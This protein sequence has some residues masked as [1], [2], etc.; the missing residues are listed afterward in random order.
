MNS[1]GTVKVYKVEKSYRVKEKGTNSYTSKR[2]KDERKWKYKLV[3]TD[4]YLRHRRLSCNAKRMA[5]KIY[6][7]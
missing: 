7:C 6:V 5:K 1:Y 3:H 4:K 2:H